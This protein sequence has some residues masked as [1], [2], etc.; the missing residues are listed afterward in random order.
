[1]GC[2][3]LFGLLVAVGLVHACLS[4]LPD[5]CLDGQPQPDSEKF[6]CTGSLNAS[7]STIVRGAF[8][9]HNRLKSIYLRKNKITLIEEGAFEG[10]GN[11]L[12]ALDL[13]TNDIQMIRRNTFRGLHKLLWLT[14]SNNRITEIEDHAFN[15]LELLVL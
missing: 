12:L 9:E 8:L 3:W 10:L 15:G 14:L 13:S 4:S 1:M 2:A 5:Q 6:N 7:V 11:S